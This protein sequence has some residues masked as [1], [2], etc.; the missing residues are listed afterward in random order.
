MSETALT[1]QVPA[2]D[3]DL[4]SASYTED[5]RARPLDG[6]ATVTDGG[7]ISYQWQMSLDGVAWTDIPNAEQATYRPNT[8]KEPGKL[9]SITFYR[10]IAVNFLDGL[11]PS[12]DLYPSENLYPS[13]GATADAVSNT[14]KITIYPKQVKRS[15]NM[16]KFNDKRLYLKGTGN[17]TLTDP[18]TGRIV[19]QSDQFTAGSVNTSNTMGEI[20]AGV[21]LPIVAAIPSDAGLTVEFTAADFSLYEK[22][23]QVG[24]EVTYGAPV[25]MAQVVTAAGTTLSIDVSGGAPV[26]GL[27]FDTAYCYIQKVGVSSKVALDGTAYEIS[28]GGVISGFEAEN[29]VQYKVWYFVR[30]AVAQKATIGTLMDSKVLNFTVSFPVYSS[31]SKT[32]NS[33]T[34]V[35]WFYIT[36]PRLK[37]QANANVSGDQ[38]N[39]DTTVIT[40]MAISDTGDVVDAITDLCGNTGG[41]L[42]YYVYSPCDEAEVVQGLVVIGGLVSVAT[43]SSRQ[44]PVMFA[45]PDNSLVHPTSYSTGFTYTGSGLPS[46]TSVSTSGLVTAGSTA[47]DGEVIVTYTDGVSSFELPVNVEVYAPSP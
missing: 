37:L 19:Y 7:E 10:V 8:V 5:D 36:V 33:G 14:A 11:F 6:T 39:A 25:P 13:D 28:A 30:K 47:G 46:E 40:G 44:I 41:D 23:A 9:Q 22:A 4:I 34:R 12:E 3:A 29:G 21:G 16:I 42:A 1:A 31:L 26:A 18:A 24:S 17:A 2:F 20:R 35:G 32:N 43:G 38:S 45:M 27:G 15:E